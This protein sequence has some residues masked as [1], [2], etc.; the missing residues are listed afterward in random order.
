MTN[1]WDWVQKHNKRERQRKRCR[2]FGI[3]MMLFFL[4]FVIGIPP[5]FKFNDE[6][7]PPD[8]DQDQPQ[9]GT[10][11]DTEEQP[12]LDSES[13]RIAAS[14]VAEPE[15][16]TYENPPVET[17][18]NSTPPPVEPKSPSFASSIPARKEPTPDPEQKRA[19][20]RAIA[21]L[22]RKI[23]QVDGNEGQH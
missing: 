10:V 13:D 21:Q 2:I 12:P 19:A 5:I 7:Q 23:E 16:T 8:K 15:R 4:L 20:E 3:I 18:T 9:A 6:P 11:A 14:D 1:S 17:P 22:N